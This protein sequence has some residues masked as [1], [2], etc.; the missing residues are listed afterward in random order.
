VKRRRLG[1]SRKGG[2]REEP[3]GLTIGKRRTLRALTP[4][5]AGHRVRFGSIG[6]ASLLGG[7][8][9][10]A[11]IVLLARVAFAL[12]AQNT[13]EIQIGPLPE[14]EI[15]IPTV[16][17]IAVVLTLMR[18]ALLYLQSMETARLNAD[19]LSTLRRDSIECYLD[20]PWSVQSKERQGS[21]Q[22]LMSNFATTAA[23][24]A[25]YL[26][27]VM[28][29]ALTLLSLLVV[30]LAVNPL[31]SLLVALVAVGLSML[32]YPMRGILRRH[33]SEAAEANLAFATEVSEVSSLAL[34]IRIYGADQ[35]VNQRVN[36]HITDHARKYY[37]F[38]VLSA[39]A[40]GIFQTIGLLL[41][42]GGVAVIYASDFTRFASAGAI[43]LIMFRSLSY[44]QIFQ[45]AYQKLHEIVPYVDRVREQQDRYRVSAVERTGQE[46][47][48]IR[49]L[50]FDSVSFGYTPGRFVL[51]DVSFEIPA[52][53]VV[54]I[55]GPSGAGKST[56]VGLLLRLHAPSSGSIR[57]NGH[58]ISVLSLDEWYRRTAFVPQDSRLISG[59]IADNIRFFRDIDDE[60]I[61]RAARLAHVH[62]EIVARPLG[63]ESHV[64]ARGDQ[65]SGGQ[66]Q[67]LCIARAL[68]SDP[69]VVVL[70]EPT[71]ALDARS[72][73]LVRQTMTELAPAKTVII[74]AHRLSTLD[75]CD[76]IMVLKEG[77][78]QG[79][80]EPHELETSNAFYR[81]ALR[82]AGMR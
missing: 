56:L 21:L 62:E 71:S 52:G 7:F 74:I 30:S 51:Q 10:A 44:A 41:I 63:Y 76:R 78:L 19:I 18:F 54:G 80:D 23:G 49:S 42:F 45:S 82:M 5:L 4:L 8:A 11:V 48:P 26:A 36:D 79:F 3:T 32:L 13:I 39:I 58:D 1:R 25:G 43:V 33:S 68:A 69:D 66:R 70:D 57:A 65:L 22:E 64:G 47:G 75:L 27:G 2:A 61:E 34:E 72:E 28:T 12:V 53:W 73:M 16:V 67:R 31:A 55:V 59:T 6:A 24:A 40:P 29:A 81:E 17:G 15:P 38:S 14:W 37:S 50:E 35:A 9:E 46:V 20:A 77:Q 60:A